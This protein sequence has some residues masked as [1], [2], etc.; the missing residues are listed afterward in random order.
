M[1]CSKEDVEAAIQQFYSSVDP[2]VRKEAHNFLLAVQ[3]DPAALQTVVELLS[4]RCDPRT[5]FFAA[6]CLCIIL[7][8]HWICDEM[9]VHLLALKDALLEFSAWQVPQYVHNRVLHALSL[10]ILRS[11]PDIWSDPLQELLQQQTSW[12]IGDVFDITAALPEE[13]LSFSCQPERRC[14]IRGELLKIEPRVLKMLLEFF[15]LPGAVGETYVT[16]KALNCATEWVQFTTNLEAWI[17]VIQCCF[18]C[19]D[20][21]GLI[22]AI[23]SFFAVVVKHPKLDQYPSFLKLLFEYAHKLR[24]AFLREQVEI[25][26]DT[27]TAW[28]TTNMII[29]LSERHSGFMLQQLSEPCVGD[30]LETLLRITEAPG[31]Y[32]L[33]ERVS[34]MA[35]EFWFAFYSDVVEHNAYRKASWWPDIQRVFLR[36][37]RALMRKARLSEQLLS[38]SDAECKED[39]KAYRESCGDNLTACYMLLG[40]VLCQE[41]LAHCQL[42]LSNS[43][44]MASEQWEDVEC[45]LF[46]F[47]SIADVVNSENA[48]G[49]VTFLQHTLPALPRSNVYVLIAMCQTIKSLTS[50]IERYNLYLR[51]V[52]IILDG[53]SSIQTLDKALAALM[54]LT[55]SKSSSTSALASAVE[56]RLVQYLESREVPS[57]IYLRLLTCYG[58]I[59]SFK[60]PSVGMPALGKALSPHMQRLQAVCKGELSFTK[61]EVLFE[62]DCV[63]HQVKAL[64]SCLVEGPHKA[65]AISWTLEFVMPICNLLKP[66]YEVSG[67]DGELAASICALVNTLLLALKCDAKPLLPAFFTIV[68][69]LFPPHTCVFPFTKN[70][71]ILFSSH[72]E[73]RES[74]LYVFS[75]LTANVAAGLSSSDA[76]DLLEM[77]LTFAIGVCQKCKSK[78]GSHN[79]FMAASGAD[80]SVSVRLAAMAISF[81]EIGLVRLASRFLSVLLK[82]FNEDVLGPLLS[83]HGHAIAVQCFE[84]LQKE[85]LAYC[86]EYLCDILFP[87]TREYATFLGPFFRELPKDEYVS[88]MFAEMSNKRRFVEAAKR[89]NMHC[90]KAETRV[91]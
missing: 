65:N 39:F 56:S 91:A 7:R 84:R 68:Q 10:C 58:R 33:D 80:L 77:Y 24:S 41:L 81:N 30:I 78:T 48:E 63:V 16:E 20:N 5:H 67:S 45:I 51:L 46:F 18:S 25:S 60:D 23:G 14:I 76:I 2:S 88:I 28:E 57:D 11:V 47:Q 72:P 74:L 70:V 71:F 12:Q 86:V 40:D 50:V 15:A 49:V 17:T 37:F 27:P 4:Q 55:E 35:H 66:L 29:T 73:C 26:E 31:A 54:E 36:L 3:S 19:A 75:Y 43:K 85:P 32:P 79:N 82:V 90:R 59:L 22:A 53:L 64:A 89:F 1:S 38:I 9:D 61:A 69:L 62:I 21:E 44:I 6:N 83:E 8:S 87:L 13:F 52:D 34:V 42:L